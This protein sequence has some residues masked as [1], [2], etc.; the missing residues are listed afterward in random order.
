MVAGWSGH[1]K[2]WSLASSGSSTVETLSP[3]SPIRVPGAW[4]VVAARLSVTSQIG[5]APSMRIQPRSSISTR[6]AVAPMECASAAGD[7]L[8]SGD[9]SV[10]GCIA[11]SA[12]R[13][14][15]QD[16]ANYR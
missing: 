3:I 11:T 4:A 2:L 5:G 15:V 9:K 12:Y 14:T 6:E 7:S 8:T 10:V 13:R 16:H 1:T